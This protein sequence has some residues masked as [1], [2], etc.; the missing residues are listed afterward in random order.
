MAQ[1]AKTLL[2]WSYPGRNVG[3]LNRGVMHFP[4]LMLHSQHLACVKAI[5]SHA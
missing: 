3:L 5:T 4:D 2:P 1:I